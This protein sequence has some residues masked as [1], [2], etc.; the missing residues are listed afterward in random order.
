MGTSRLWVFSK[1]AGPRIARFVANLNRERLFDRLKQHR[2]DALADRWT[3]FSWFGIRW[4][5]KT[6]E[7]A[8]E[9]TG[10]NSKIG[11]VLN[12]IEAILISAAEPPHNRQAGRFGDD[13]KQ[14]LQW[15][16]KDSLG[17]TQDDMIRDIWKRKISN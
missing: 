8:A 3:K 14:Y 15:R 1:K 2:K 5:T 7:L 9:V 12:H 6:N 10:I 11:A 4:V 17:P 16:D 13:I